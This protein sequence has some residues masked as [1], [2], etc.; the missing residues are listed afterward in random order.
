MEFVKPEGKVQPPQTGCKKSKQKFLASNLAETFYVPSTARG[1]FDC[2]YRPTDSILNIVVRLK[3][4]FDSIS[5]EGQLQI[6][7]NLSQGVPQYWDGACT[8]RCMRHGWTDITVQPRFSVDFGSPSHFKLVITPEDERAKG[9]LTRECRGFVSMNQVTSPKAEDR[10]EL[11]DFQTREFNHAA[12]GMLNAGNDREFLEKALKGCGATIEE[13]VRNVPIAVLPFGDSSSEASALEPVMRAFV[14]AA[15]K[16]TRG[17]HPVPVLVKG[18]VKMSE[19]EA[20]AVRRA[21]AVQTFLKMTAALKNP[22]NIAAENGTGKPA[23]EVSIDH[24]YEG[25][26]I[27]GEREFQ[28]NVAAHE[29]GHMIGLPDEYENPDTGAKA[30]VKKNFQALL[31]RAGLR[32]PEFPSHNSSMMSDGMTMMP[33]HYVT[34]WEALAYLTR[35][36]LAPG[37]WTI[38]VPG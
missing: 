4:T 36:F 28:Y 16:Q 34:A 30:I 10:A 38:N 17:S 33:W 2:S 26:F 5:S 9:K 20:L 14:T 21:Q 19:P 23:V 1:K 7:T 13:K 6:K 24:T 32:G 25:G 15:N 29:F 18:F 11:R 35:G 22:V 12:G 27:T 37:D 3:A 31:H 8:F